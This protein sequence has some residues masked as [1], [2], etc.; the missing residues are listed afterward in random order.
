LHNPYLSEGLVGIVWCPD[1][2]LVPP[3]LTIHISSLRDGASRRMAPRAASP[4]GLQL[5][6]SARTSV[7]YGR[8]PSSRKQVPA[9]ANTSRTKM[10]PATAGGRHSLS[11][12]STASL[13]L[14]GPFSRRVISS[15]RPR[16]R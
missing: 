8:K 14:A 12:S 11:T 1:P 7:S 16:C 3:Y 15:S 10:S 5:K 6:V 13:P 2:P 4:A 9:L